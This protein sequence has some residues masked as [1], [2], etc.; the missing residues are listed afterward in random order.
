MNFCI[1]RA[2]YIGLTIAAVLADISHTVYCTDRDS[3]KIDKLK[4][5]IVYGGF[6]F[7]KD[8]NSLSYSASAKQLK[9]ELLQ[10]VKQINRSQLG[11]YMN[12]LNHKLSVNIRIAVW[13]AMFKE[14]KDD[15]RYSPAIAFIKKLAKQGFQV[16]ACDPIVF[17]R[18]GLD[19]KTIEAYGFE[20]AGVERP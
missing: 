13:G 8:I 10:A 2:G 12:K 9:M 7:P 11:I 5:G 1:V 14:N 16:Y 3:L 6:C 19:K 18:N 20:F 4:K 17:G 15:I